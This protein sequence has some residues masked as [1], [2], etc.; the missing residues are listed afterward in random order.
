MDGRGLQSAGSL[1]VGAGGEFCIC[2]SC[3]L[4]G[5][6]GHGGEAAA[7]D[8][9]RW[10]G[11]GWGSRRGLRRLGATGGSKL[12]AEVSILGAE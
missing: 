10:L 1:G 9:G 12:S 2:F 8:Y 3:A 11:K 7:S 6:I 4:H 5:H